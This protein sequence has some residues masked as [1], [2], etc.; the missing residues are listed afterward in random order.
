M[1]VRAATPLGL[2]WIGQHALHLRPGPA[3]AVDLAAG[4]HGRRVLVPGLPFGG[5]QQDNVVVGRDGRLYFGS[6]STCDVVHGDAT[7]RSATILSMRPDG[8][9]LRIVRAGPAQPVRARVQPGERTPVR[10]GERPGRARHARRPEPAEMLVARPQRRQ[11]RLAGV[12]AELEPEADAGTCTG[13]TPPVAYLSRTPRPTGSP[14]RPAR[15][16]A[17]LRRHVFVALWGQ[18]L[19]PSP[20]S[21][22]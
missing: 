14:S 15:L 12:L 4:R 17:R 10:D 21:G 5:H 18:Y 13:V 11:V 1:L 16:P 6:G 22:S 3:R 9:D 8:S 2:A 20:A 19:A 7:A